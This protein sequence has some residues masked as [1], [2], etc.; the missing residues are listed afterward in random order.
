MK[1][2]FLLLF[3][4]M[5]SMAFSQEGFVID[6]THTDLSQIPDN[7]IDSAKQNL[8]IRYFRR[9]HGSQIDVGGMAA[10]QRYSAYNN[11]YT[12]N[13]TG[14]NGE[15]FLSTQASTEW[16]SLDYE[17]DI[18]VQITRDYLDDLANSEI[19]VVMWAW[20]SSFYLCSAQQ[21]INDMETL[22][23]EYGPGGSKNRAVP[24]TFI[25]QT[26]CGQRS[27][28]RNE[29]VYL[30][31]D[32]IRKHC[33]NNN[34]ILFDF[35]DLEC[36]DPDGNYYG[37]GVS[38]G[39]YTNI[40][41]LNDDLAYISDSTNVS[42][43]PGGG[44]WGIEW[45]NRN[46]DKELTLISAN[47][48][49]TVCEHSDQRG[50][51]DPPIE[52]NSRLHCV[53]K[54][55]A[56]W[57]MW[58]K[59]AGWGIKSLAIE[60][61]QPLNEESLDE[62]TINLTLMGDSFIDNSLNGANFQLNNVPIGTTVES[63]VYTDATHAVLNLAFDG[64]DFD[65][66]SLHFSITISENEL[67]SGSSITSNEIYITAFDENISITS[68][69]GLTE[70]NLDNGVLNLTLTNT[71]FLDNQLNAANFQLNNA[72]SGTSI[73]SI[74]Y[75][76]ENSAEINLAF[77]GTDF[78]ID[79]PNF[80]TTV[81]SNEISANF[82]LTSNE[83][84]I[85]AIDELNPYI[86]I[87]CTVNLIETNLDQSTVCIELYNESFTDNQLSIGNFQLIN[88]PQGCSV[89]QVN[90]TSSTQAD[91]NLSFD[92]TDFDTDINNFSIR[93][94][95]EELNG[96]ENLE[97]DYL[98]IEAVEE[99]NI[100]LQIF[101]ATSLTETLLNNTL[102]QLKL[103][104]LSFNDNVLEINN[105]VLNNVP[106][107]LSVNN[108]EYI[109]TDSAVLSLSFDGTDFDSDYVN[110]SVTVLESELNQTGSITCDEQTIFSELEPNAYLETE[111][112]LKESLLNNA[113]L[114]IL[115][116]DDSF[117][118]G[119]SITDLILNNPP[120]GLTITTIDLQNDTNL[121]LTMSFNGTN[122]DSDIPDFSVSIDASRINSVEN[123]TT[124]EITIIA[125]TASS[126]ENINVIKSAKIYPNPNTGIFKLKLDLEHQVKLNIS[127]V[128]L[129]GKDILQ[130][131]Y[132]GKL[133]ANLIEF[134]LSDE[135]SGIQIL[136]IKFEDKQLVLPIIKN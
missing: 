51:Y 55:R 86:S 5:S 9:S 2:K 15:L 96:T 74:L 124:N 76:D 116:D 38:D 61:D 60:A 70:T 43:H 39:S 14:A 130:K 1:T 35:N 102:I 83:I 133:G 80:S 65:Q 62:R 134:D 57:W 128:N 93:I 68:Q 67:T 129:L 106:V 29:L 92:G 37:D 13:K 19:N 23:S 41:L 123:L 56:A 115:L 82:N 31:N 120:D 10:L 22:I 99:N 78:E 12:F 18:W 87:S 71:N 24:V 112:D 63:V 44:N 105:F 91:L 79:Y 109:S 16:N 32:T 85:E 84:T 20:S 21:Y 119:I 131:E 132:L 11:L 4:L 45:M 6:H 17:N 107:G 95:A 72:P 69:V 136:F 90:Y 30:K 46:P 50:N 3:L 47:D 40:R 104:G 58:A 49:C 48:I 59:L 125:E 127:V 53:L 33:Y 135:N 121:V 8:K 101:S 36:Y 81:M 27:I 26:A 110:F 73:V 89:Q 25:F 94:L 122:F 34:R 28:S 97:S 100:S 114:N 54:G 103:N 111:S 42:I 117:D 7:W 88:A 113:V 98:S 64:S 75:I 66:D 52:D 108:V 77:N 118:S 126:I